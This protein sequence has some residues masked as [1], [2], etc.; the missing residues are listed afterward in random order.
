MVDTTNALRWIKG[1]IDEFFSTTISATESNM[2]IIRNQSQGD[3][4]KRL[5][6]RQRIFLILVGK[7][8]FHVATCPTPER[9]K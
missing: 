7:M 6:T 3:A 5:A 9:Q 1:S 8:K 2:P 4:H